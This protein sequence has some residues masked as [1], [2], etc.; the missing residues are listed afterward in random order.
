MTIEE[1]ISEISEYKNTETYENPYI[2][3]EKRENLRIYLET[4]KMKQVSVLFVGEA[5][6]YLGCSITGIPFTDERVLK[7]TEFSFIPGWGNYLVQGTQKERSAKAIWDVLKSLQLCE[8]PLLWNIFPFHP[9]IEGNVLSNRTP[10][11]EEMQEIGIHFLKEIIE[12]FGVREVYAIGLKAFGSLS[13]MDIDDIFIKDKGKSYIRH[14]SYGGK[15][16]CQNRIKEIYSV[17]KSMIT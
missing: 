5:P 17:K 13:D 12:I 6:G 7:S 16:E 1:F 4:M 2:I 9:F 15:N 11:K 3:P 8:L 14:P 10:T